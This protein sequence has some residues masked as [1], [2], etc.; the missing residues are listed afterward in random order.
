MPTPDS[1]ASFASSQA[2]LERSFREVIESNSLP[3]TQAKMDFFLQKDLENPRREAAN[4]RLKAIAD[5][6]INQSAA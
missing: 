6:I 1:L 4:R 3:V 2:Q 5:S